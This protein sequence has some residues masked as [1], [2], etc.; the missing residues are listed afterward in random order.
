MNKSKQK[1]HTGGERIHLYPFDRLRVIHQLIANQTFPTAK[2]LAA[3]LEVS[4]RTIRRYIAF[5]R[6]RFN[7]PI[8]FDPK[9]KGFGYTHPNWEMPLIA[10]TEGELLA[11]FIATIALQGKG[12]TYE[13]ERLRRAVAKIAGSLPEAVSVSLGYLFE[14]T[15]FQAPPHVRVES[16]ILDVLHKAISQ[17]EIVKFDYISTTSGE[18]KNRRVE[19]LLL[20]NYEG[21]WYVIA[22]DYLRQEELVFHTGRIADLETTGDYFEPRKDFVKENYFGETFGMYRGGKSTE[23]EIIFDDHQSKWMRE[24]NFFHPQEIREEMPDGRLKL[25]FYRRR[26]RTRSCRADFVCNM[27]EISSRSNRKSL[28]K[29]SKK[30]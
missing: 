28:K 14:N 8:K 3:D 18:T 21:T 12:S 5:M 16:K 4:V 15:S 30:S 25:N 24:R 13:D 6:E 9:K 19:P 1:S 27:Q 22:F 29:L 26:K 10:L 2:Q 7:A 11:F 17:R 20:H 23:V